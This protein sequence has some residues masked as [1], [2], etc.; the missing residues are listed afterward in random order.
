[1]QLA[2]RH[3]A[4]STQISRNASDTGIYLD[5]ADF[6]SMAGSLELEPTAALVMDWA[7][8]LYQTGSAAAFYAHLDLSAGQ[9]MRK[10][11]D[12]VCPWYPE[13]MMNRKWFIRYLASGMISGMGEPCQVILLASGKSPLALELLEI[14]PDTVAAVIESDIAGMD[15]KERLY[16]TVAPTAAKKIRCVTADL[17]DHAG[18]ADSIRDT[19]CWFPDCPSVIIFEGISYYIPPA[20]ASGVLRR[21]ASES[22]KNFLILD[23]LSPCRLVREDRRYISRGIWNIIHRDCHIRSTV[24]YS[25]E[26]LEAMLSAAGA[27]QVRSHTMHEMEYLRTGRNRYFPTPGHGWIQVAAARL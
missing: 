15:E 11:C 14:H 18:T 5:E 16:H 12:G 25:L 23:Y 13:V 6:S 3:P 9:R 20:A 8:D 22:R 17:Y 19:G 2:I 1:V 4:A 21:F 24:T 26:E 27:G 7:K 10:E